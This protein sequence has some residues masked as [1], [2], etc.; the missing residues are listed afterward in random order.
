M[1]ST[2]RPKT[3]VKGKAS[4]SGS[5]LSSMNS[6]ARTRFAERA[7]MAQERRDQIAVNAQ[8]KKQQR[9]TSRKSTNKTPSHSAKKQQHSFSYWLFNANLK[10]VFTMLFLGNSKHT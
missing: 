5:I 7:N 9:D 3:K 10:D 4:S 2:P 8:Q 1:C 6:E